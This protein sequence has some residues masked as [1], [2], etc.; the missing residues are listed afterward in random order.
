MQDARS[1]FKLH[2][3]LTRQQRKPRLCYLVQ[4]KSVPELGTPG[5]KQGE[6]DTAVCLTARRPPLCLTQ[7]WSGLSGTDRER[8]HPG[9][10]AGVLRGQRGREASGSEDAVRRRRYWAVVLRT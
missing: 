1:D 4:V 2:P 10:S 7:R 9:A 6:A 3:H 5:G 8:S